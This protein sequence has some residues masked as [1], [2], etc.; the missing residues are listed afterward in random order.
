M[1]DEPRLDRL[2]ETDFVREKCARPRRRRHLARDP[3]LVGNELDATPEKPAGFRSQDGV[4]VHESAAT[5]VE[6]STPVPE[7]GEQPRPR[8]C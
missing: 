5:D 8:A 7:P 3:E 2:P 4:A 6:A 1:D